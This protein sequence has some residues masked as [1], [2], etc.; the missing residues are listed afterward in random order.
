MK[1]TLKQC[2]CTVNKR[3]GQL[4]F[5]LSNKIFLPESVP[6][7][8]AS[9]QLEELDYRKLYRAYSAKG[10]KS[11]A[12]PRVLLKVA[13]NQVQSVTGPAGSYT[14]NSTVQCAVSLRPEVS[15]SILFSPSVSLGAAIAEML[16]LA[17]ETGAG[18]SV[19]ASTRLQQSAW[20]TLFHGI[21]F[22]CA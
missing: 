5:A 19:S 13:L 3:Y 9:A 14:M 21:D 11:K 17:A 15:T 12:D 1:Q 10:K 18:S 7:R 6:V 20:K 4:V 2:Q 22:L 16:L 8:L